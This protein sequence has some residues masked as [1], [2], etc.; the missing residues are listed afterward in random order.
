MSNSPGS[1]ATGNIESG[2][3]RE[4][5]QQPY[6]LLL[7]P[8][9][10]IQQNEASSATCS[11]DNTTLFSRLRRLHRDDESDFLVDIDS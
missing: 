1:G 2:W 8:L 4:I 11:K 6:R 5:R 7:L 9:I 3:S 10:V